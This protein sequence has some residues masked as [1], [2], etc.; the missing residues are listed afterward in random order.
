MKRTGGY[1]VFLF[2]VFIV[3]VFFASLAL[4]ASD[5]PVLSFKDRTFFFF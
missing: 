4:T 1:G 5:F 3:V 2:F